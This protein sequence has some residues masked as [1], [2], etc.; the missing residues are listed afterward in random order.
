M[1]TTNITQADWHTELAARRRKS[2]EIAQQHGCDALLIF[3]SAGQDQPFRYL[4]NF[5]P[6]FGDSW[7]ILTGPEQMTCVLNFDWQLDEARAASGLQDWHGIFHTPPLVAELL[8]DSRPQKVGVVGLHRLPVEAYEIIRAAL[9]NASFSN[10]GQDV[11]ALRRIK[12]PLEIQMLRIAA[13]IVD[14]ALDTIRQEI[15]PGMTEKQVN[16]RMAFIMQDMGGEGFTGA[17]VVS[18]N[19]QPIVIRMPTHRKLEVGDS[20]MIDSG[21]S[22]LGYQADLTRTFVL[23]QPNARQQKVWDTIRRAYDAVLQRTRPGVPF[24]E[25]HRTAVSIIEG[26]G[27][28]LPHRVGHGIGLAH[29]FEWPSLDSETTPMQP[30]MTFCLEPGIYTPGAG[31]MKLEDEILVTEDG[32]NLLSHANRELVVPLE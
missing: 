26:A 6:I 14:T 19:D 11:A 3:G 1:A 13:G 29:S 22:C 15:R 5:L 24:V 2:W 8:A 7:G 4:T 21:T 31:S 25:L 10:I 32:F 23:G 30:G 9:P 27:Y 18:G 12:S 17:V 20:V 16:A 28:R